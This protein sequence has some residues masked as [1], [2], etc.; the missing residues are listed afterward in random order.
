M[1]TASKT[2]SHTLHQSSVEVEP[3]LIPMKELALVAP[4]ISSAAD[5]LLGPMDRTSRGLEPHTWVQVL[6]VAAVACSLEEHETGVDSPKA[7]W[8]SV[9]VDA[10]ETLDELVVGIPLVRIRACIA[11]KAPSESKDLVEVL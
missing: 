6:M 10:C 4:T 8:I 1:R 9:V 11:G 3:C 5:I 7:G 2:L